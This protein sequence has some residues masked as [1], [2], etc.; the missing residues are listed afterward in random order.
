MLLATDNPRAATVTKNGVVTGYDRGTAVITAT[1]KET[2][3]TSTINIKVINAIVQIVKDDGSVDDKFETLAE[4]TIAA[5][6]GKSTITLL[7]D[8]DLNT[9]DN[10]NNS[11]A[12]VDTTQNIV[13][14]LNGHN[15]MIVDD[16]SIVVNG[17]FTIKDSVGEG[18]IQIEEGTLMN[19]S[20]TS[21]VIIESGRIGNEGT[22]VLQSRGEVEINGGTIDGSNSFSM[23]GDVSK[24]TVNGGNINGKVWAISS[25]TGKVII[26]DGTITSTNID[27]AT[28]TTI[29]AGGGTIEVNGGTVK[30]SENALATIYMKGDSGNITINGG[31]VISFA[32]TDSAIYQDCLTGNIFVYG[33][34]ISGASNVIRQYRGKSIKVSKTGTQPIRITQNGTSAPESTAA[35]RKEDRGNIYIGTSSDGNMYNDQMTIQYTKCG[36]VAQDAEV[37]IYNGYLHGSEENSI[38]AVANAKAIT[39]TPAVSSFHT[40]ATI[41]TVHNSTNKCVLEDIIF[42]ND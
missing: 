22:A 3:K 2:G 11:A 41:E 14:D 40:S 9:H 21:K 17:T 36:I 28:T 18:S 26:N 38:G 5:K 20:A 12:T 23:K 34:E 30:S 39:I 25:D 6:G 19:A 35:I 31:K 10:P 24:I 13:L 27:S 37:E 1:D 42:T 29:K 32:G 7:R 16:D 8:A 15:A 4:A 33:G